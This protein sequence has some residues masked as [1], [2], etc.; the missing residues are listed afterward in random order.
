[1]H[2]IHYLAVHDILFA[3]YSRHID[4]PARHTAE[5]LRYLQR[6]HV[7][8]IRLHFPCI[9]QIRHS[10]GQS[11]YDSGDCHREMCRRRVAGQVRCAGDST[12]HQA[13][14]CPR[15]DGRSRRVGLPVRHRQGTTETS[16]TL[17]TFSSHDVERNIER[18]RSL[19]Y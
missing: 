17:E 3:H 11:E 1:M 14:H 15:L 16:Q 6:V 5:N 2:Q 13:T 19:P 7:E 9:P 10:A 18:K 4:V 12:Q 8:S